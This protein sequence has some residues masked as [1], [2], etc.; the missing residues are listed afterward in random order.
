ML[1]YIKYGNNAIENKYSR[2]EISEALEEI[3]KL[4]QQG[5]LFSEEP[6]R[7]ALPDIAARE[8]VIKALCLHVAH[9]CNLK[10]RY[11]FAREGTYGGVRSLM[12]LETGRAAVD[13]LIKN[14]G[15]RRN[16]EI[17]FFGGEPLLNFETV[18]GIVQYGREAEKRHGKHIRFTLT[19][20]GLLLDD[21]SERFLNEEMHNIVLSL[22]G[23]REVHDNMRVA[24]GGQG[25]YDAALPKLRHLVESR[26]HE[27]Y[28]VRGTFTRANLDFCEDALHLADLGFRRISLEPVVDCTGA[29]YAIT[30]ED[31]DAISAEY[32][33]LALKMLERKSNGQGFTFFHYVIDLTGGPCVAKRLTGCGAG[34]EYLAVAP[35][36]ALYPCHQFVGIA[37]FEMGRLPEGNLDAGI[38]GRFEKCRPEAKAACRECFAKF[39][40]CGGCAAAAYNASGDIMKPYEIGCELE[41]KRVECAIMLEAAGEKEA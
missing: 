23:R 30:P 7:E 3:T 28:Y 39:Y 31:L 11:C 27:N 4:K 38:R 33:R 15:S 36:G 37:G 14:S 22:D 2:Y 41:R 17:D 32:E 19:T 35:D 8:P 16:L 20:N 40:C 24:R 21:E 26:G 12:S 34:T 25:S 9:D 1:D 10:C 6:P 18:K 29:D 5:M 13:F